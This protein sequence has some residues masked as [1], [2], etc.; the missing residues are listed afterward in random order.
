MITKKEIETMD[1]VE[2]P[3]LS[4]QKN[5]LSPIFD[6]QKEHFFRCFIEMTKAHVIM[7]CEQDIIKKKDAGVILEGICDVEQIHFE[8]REYDPRFEDMFFMFERS[9]EEKIGG[10]L[11]GQVHTARSRNDIGVAEF[12]LVMRDELVKVM[13]SILRLKDSLLTLIEGN[14]DT[15]M[16]MYTHT[17]PAQ[18]STLAHYLLAMYDVLSR[19][20]TRLSA[21]EKSINRSPLGAAAITT[22]GFPISRER[23]SELLGFDGLLENSYD[24]IAAADHTMEF[25][26]TLMVL[27]V[28]MSR[29][30]KDILDWCTKE[31]GFFYLADGYVQKSSIMPQ[32]RNPSSL[33]HCRPI[34]SKALAEAQA[35]FTI[36]H[37]T[38]YGDIVDSEEELQEHIYQSVYYLTRAMNLTANVLGTMKINKELLLRRAHENFITVT[39]LADTLV[40]EAGL[41]FREAHTITSAI[42]KK[43][44][45]ANQT[46][47]DIDQAFVNQV[48]AEILG[49]EAVVDAAMIQKA[50]DP[51]H[52]VEIRSIV[53]GPSP[54]TAAG[55]YEE[56]KKNFYIEKGYV[57]ALRSK[58]SNA[59]KKLNTIVQA[60]IDGKDYE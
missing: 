8:E 58:Y 54:K 53:G 35:I 21:V 34:I 13:D 36:M 44:Y 6:I 29:F 31:F 52:F 3:A 5:V 33:E 49:R 56:R 14:L 17:Q 30:M 1:G 51:V 39:E 27:C 45:S 24:C 10:S 47:E 11:A 59:K 18:P 7:L 46:A 60:I 57:E 37:N 28:D 22:T 25:A 42:V 9:L 50:L 48:S 19:D 16:P 15:V 55:M 40:R 43:L 26:G 12:R 2:F 20:F 38:P 23:T 32:K 41:S 4:F